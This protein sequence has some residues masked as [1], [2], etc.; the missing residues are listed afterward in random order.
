MTIADTIVADTVVARSVSADSFI[1]SKTSTPID[2]NSMGLNGNSL[3]WTVKSI[4]LGNAVVDFTTSNANAL[5]VIKTT[6]ADG[7]AL[8]TL[9]NGSPGQIL[10]LVSVV[11]G[12]RANNASTCTLTPSTKTGFETIVFSN[13]ITD[14]IEFATL[15]F[16]DGTVGWTIMGTNV[17]SITM[18]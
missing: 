8:W 6:T 13:A 3:N 12:S 17:A 11:T 5:V 1:S 10:H 14:I 16:V 15:I 7:N 9:A 2:F 4:E 18:S